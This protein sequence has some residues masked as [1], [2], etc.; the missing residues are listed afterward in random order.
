MDVVTVGSTK[1][2]TYCVGNTSQYINNRHQKQGRNAEEEEGIASPDLGL[3]SSLGERAI[4]S[5]ALGVGI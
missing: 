1:Q 4:L 5:L 3:Q 2:A